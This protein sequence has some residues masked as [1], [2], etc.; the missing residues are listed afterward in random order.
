MNPSSMP[1][2]KPAT[3]VHRI[4][5]DV[6]NAT[7]E[8]VAR[9]PVDTPKSQAAY[10]DD[11]DEDEDFRPG[12]RQLVAK[13]KKSSTPT[14][15]RK[16]RSSFTPQRKTIKFFS[17][18][19]L[20]S[21]AFSDASGTGM[22]CVGYRTWMVSHKA[23]LCSMTIG[24]IHIDAVNDNASVQSA[25]A[26]DPSSHSPTG[27]AFIKQ[28]HSAG[29]VSSPSSSHHEPTLELKLSGLLPDQQVCMYKESHVLATSVSADQTRLLCML[30]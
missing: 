24:A 4:A 19:A 16:P 12:H 21:E 9:A 28:S 1:R 25:N 2:R 27:P 5:G 20:G 22:V 29:S 8:S 10:E 6:W 7:R 15:L 23:G 30:L 26:N 3:P 18:T 14:S 11:T 13:R 17:V